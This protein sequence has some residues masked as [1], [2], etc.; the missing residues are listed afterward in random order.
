M[1]KI[2]KRKIIRSAPKTK[3]A[4][5]QESVGGESPQVLEK[6]DVSLEDSRFDF[7]GY[8]DPY[9]YLKQYLRTTQ[10]N[11]AYKLSNDLLEQLTQEGKE[12]LLTALIQH[13]AKRFDK[14]ISSVKE[15]DALKPDLKPGEY[16]YLNGY[17]RDLY[18]KQIRQLQ[19][20]LIK[21][22]NWV[23]K[24]G[25]KI[26]LIFEGRDAA[27]KGGTIQRFIEH[28]NPRF[29]RV[30]A[31]P[32]PTETESG[33][34]YFQRYVAHLPTNGEMV[35]FDRSWYNRAVV[36]PVM[37]FCTQDQYETFIKE[38]PSFEKNILSSGIILFKFWLD[39]SRKEQKRRFKQRRKDP[40]KQ[41]KL[42]PVD[43]A[44][45]SKWDDY[46][47][48]IHK[49]FF[50]TDTQDA[51]WTVI[52]SDDKMRARINAI[53]LVLSN[54]DYTGRDLSVIGEVDPRIVYRA[55]SITGSI[56]K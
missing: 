18:N 28:L 47:K 45:L 50:E 53:R 49:M 4:P 34:W 33:Q 44:S 10:T 29:A 27:G 7:G 24:K 31:L 37:G 39:V 2:S 15:M 16:P 42:S 12:R 14:K 55:N 17:N 11:D 5:T 52:E 36:E 43:L 13:E 9:Q 8:E 35:F 6:A 56:E 38:V 32:K 20:E 48:A 25:K 40:L 21:L 51:P 41:W 19:I 54:I 22:Q 23:Q 30:A 46:T 26:V 3:D 1:V